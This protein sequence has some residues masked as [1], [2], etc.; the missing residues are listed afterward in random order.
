MGNRRGC[1]H[2]AAVLVVILLAV[3][4]LFVTCARVAAPALVRPGAPAYCSQT[5]NPSKWPECVD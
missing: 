3:A 5:A 4:V 2:P 1:A